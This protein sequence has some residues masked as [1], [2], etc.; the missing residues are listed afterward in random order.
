MASSIK[1]I[2]S[3]KAYLMT[4]IITGAHGFLGSHI[5]R[6]LENEKV[7]TIGRGPSNDL[8]C[9]LSNEIPTLPDAKVVIHCAGKAH[10]LP[11]TPEEEAEFFAVNL[12]GTQNFLKGVSNMKVLPDQF[13]FISSVAVY[14][15]EFGEMI[16][17]SHPLNGKSPYAKSKIEAEKLVQ[18]WGCSNG[19]P[20]LILRLP[21]IVGK[22]PP[23]NLGKMISGIAKGKYASIGKGKARKS[24]VAANDV[25]E[26]I[27]RVTRVEGIYNLTDGIH[28]TF[29]DLETEICQKLN[30]NIKIYVPLGIAK[31]LGK[32]GDWFPFFP[33]NSLVINKMVSDLT[34]DDT[35]ARK[36]LDWQPGPSLNSLF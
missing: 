14:G 23:G 11:K 1:W 16:P 35:L 7:F 3:E 24:M 32:I 30:L 28:P 15:K 5:L 2:Y 8:V 21:L 25:A 17:E 26:L 20:T 33:V 18:E 29:A 4:Y 13:V 34:F 27:A 19:V 10:M 36:K 22:C 31:L 6:Q 9:D 12:Q